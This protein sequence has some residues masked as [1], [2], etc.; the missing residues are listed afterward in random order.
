MIL[1]LIPRKTLLSFII[2]ISCDSALNSYKYINNRYD[3][4]LFG[5][6]CEFTLILEWLGEYFYSGSTTVQPADHSAAV[7]L[8]FHYFASELT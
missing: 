4:I 2:W 5:V 1:R 6:H 8:E 7:R 3:L